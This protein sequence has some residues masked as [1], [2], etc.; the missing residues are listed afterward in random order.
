MIIRI[1]HKLPVG[2]KVIVLDADVVVVISVGVVAI[3]I[4]ISSKG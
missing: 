1:Y 4:V 2:M 3:V